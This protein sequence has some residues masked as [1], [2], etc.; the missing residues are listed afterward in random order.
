MRSRSS[1]TQ[2][3]YG[4]VTALVESVML[5]EYVPADDQKIEIL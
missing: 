5:K 3:V 4:S 1:R 2:N